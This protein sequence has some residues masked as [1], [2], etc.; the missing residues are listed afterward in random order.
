MQLEHSA[1]TERASKETLQAAVRDYTGFAARV[2][3]GDLTATVSANG[4]PEFGELADS[5][6]TMV[7]GLAEISREIQAGRA[8]DRGLHRRDPRP[9]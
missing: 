2:A 6:N 9:R 8:R 3:D 5:L 7:S 1:E 4:S